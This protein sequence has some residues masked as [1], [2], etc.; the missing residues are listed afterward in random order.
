MVHF[1]KDLY[2]ES[3]A[4]MDVMEER[5]V[6]LERLDSYLNSDQKTCSLID[7]MKKFWIWAEKAHKMER[8]A[9]EMG[10]TNL[11][12]CEEYT[13]E[14]RNHRWVLQDMSD[15]KKLEGHTQ[16]KELLAGYE[17]FYKEH[18]FNN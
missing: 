7:L 13:E 18:Y 1:F 5:D 3:K 14:G 4:Y 12:G 2:Y 15:I 10:E 6:L 11:D 16:E 9:F 8:E 17:S